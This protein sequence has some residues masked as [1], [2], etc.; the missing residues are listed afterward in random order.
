MPTSERRF[1]LCNEKCVAY[2]D[3]HLYKDTHIL[4]ELRYLT[5]EGVRVTALALYATPVPA[6]EVPP[7]RPEIIVHIIGDA[8]LIRCKPHGKVL[9]W[10][11]G[12]SAFKQLMKRYAQSEEE[13]VSEKSI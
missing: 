11:I 9:R 8:R 1:F 4:G 12:K 7:V 13:V 2:K 3:L 6:D 10:E 5:D